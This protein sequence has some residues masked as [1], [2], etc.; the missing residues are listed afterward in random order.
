LLLLCA[1]DNPPT[2]D[3]RLGSYQLEVPESVLKRG[4]PAD[5]EAKSAKKGWRRFHTPEIRRMVRAGCGGRCVYMALP[6]RRGMM[7]ANL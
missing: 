4:Q 5:Y 1:L 7:V 6:S 2:N 3:Q